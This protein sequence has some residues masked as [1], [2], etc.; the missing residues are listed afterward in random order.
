MTQLPQGAIVYGPFLEI[1]PMQYLQSVEDVRPDVKLVNSWTVD[2]GYL[3][4]LADANA[5][6]TPLFVMEA[7]G[8]LQG[9]YA[10]VPVGSGYEVRLR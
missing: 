1:A 3:T 9:R 6:T 4:A 8:A 2:D 7:E 5:G 10:L